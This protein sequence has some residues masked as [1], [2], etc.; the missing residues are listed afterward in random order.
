[1]HF[2]RLTFGADGA[3]TI[4]RSRSQIT[5]SH[6]PAPIHGDLQDDDPTKGDDEME[7]PMELNPGINDALRT[8][9]VPSTIWEFWLGDDGAHFFVGPGSNADL[10]VVQNRILAVL[11]THQAQLAA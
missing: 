7:A 1:M 11:N 10:R 6:N 5:I 8:L 9:H 4:R 2:F 3:P